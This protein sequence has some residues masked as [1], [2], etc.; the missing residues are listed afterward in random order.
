[1]RAKYKYVF[2]LDCIINLFININFSLN[3]MR[4]YQ[5]FIFYSL[6]P[7]N[8]L[9]LFCTEY[10]CI[11]LIISIKTFTLSLRKLHPCYCI[12]IFIAIFF[13]LMTSS[14]FQL[15]NEKTHYWIILIR[16][17]FVAAYYTSFFC[18]TR[19]HLAIREIN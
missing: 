17:I 4:F 1:M 8:Y 12:N 3:F 5:D 6:G 15:W 11:Y 19:P 16:L 10:H 13:P 14:R 18:K 7:F 9:A 2:L